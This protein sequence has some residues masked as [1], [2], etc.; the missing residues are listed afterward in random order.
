MSLVVLIP[1]V[2]LGAKIIATRAGRIHKSPAEREAL[3]SIGFEWDLSGKT[4][5]NIIDAL[6][7]YR[8]LHGDYKVPKTYVVPHG[9]ANSDR[10]N[11]KVSYPEHLW[12]MKLGLKVCNIRYRGDY[13]QYKDKFE[14]ISLCLDKFGFD[15]R[16][17]DYIYSAL[18]RY[19]EIHDHLI[20]PADWAVP[21][22]DQWPKELWDLKLGYRAHNIRYRGDFVK[23]NEKYKLL[24]D[25]LGFQ[26]RKSDMQSTKSSEIEEFYRDYND[27]EVFMGVKNS[28]N[29]SNST[30]YKLKQNTARGRKQSTVIIQ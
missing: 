21:A 9:D 17:W 18:I 10:N 28:K 7:I 6:L 22:T 25:E 13:V 29:N 1:T 5:D 26:W 30:L 19:K 15:T 14:A 12:G 4:V 8:D 16:H 11:K 2:F 24:L 20:I 23:D 27:L 3:N